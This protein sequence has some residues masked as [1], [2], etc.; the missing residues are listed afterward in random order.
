MT[1]R[2]HERYSFQDIQPLTEEEIAAMSAR[3]PEG[4]G[5]NSSV[6]GKNDLEKQICFERKLKFDANAKEKRENSK[7]Y[8]ANNKVKP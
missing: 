8:W 7:K 6:F 4:W 3:G 5:R 2:Y 1:E